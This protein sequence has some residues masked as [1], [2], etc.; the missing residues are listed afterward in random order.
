MAFDHVTYY[1]LVLNPYHEMNPGD[2]TKL[3]PA[4]GRQM[5]ALAALGCAFAAVVVPVLCDN[6]ARACLNG[7]VQVC[8]S[9]Q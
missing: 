4:A 5:L 1:A 8:P 6:L 3:T 2:P 7:K 9:F